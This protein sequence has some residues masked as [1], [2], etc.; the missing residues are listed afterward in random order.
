MFRFLVCTVGAMAET[1][2]QS[3]GNMGGKTEVFYRFSENKIIKN[4]FKVRL[5]VSDTIRKIEEHTGQHMTRNTNPKEPTMPHAPRTRQELETQLAS[6]PS[7]SKLARMT[8]AEL[9]VVYEGL[10][11]GHGYGTSKQALRIAVDRVRTNITRN[12]E[13][14]NQC[15]N[16][17]AECAQEFGWNAEGLKAHALK[18]GLVCIQDMRNKAREVAAFVA[19][20]G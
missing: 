3:I 17:V 5:V 8:A 20:I 9:R 2:A 16:L 18:N 14:H 7:T 11:C 13:W 1:L 10:G 6:I 19:A 12:I 15:D 4:I